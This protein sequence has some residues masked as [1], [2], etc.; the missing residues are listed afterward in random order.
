MTKGTQRHNIFT[1]TDFVWDEDKNSKLIHERG[2]SFE[3]AMECL[4][5]GK[6]IHLYKHPN[7]W[8]YP[9]QQIAVVEINQYAYLV[10]FLKT[11]NEI[12]LKSM[13]PSRKASKK[14]L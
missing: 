1:Q 11:G 8:K 13:F 12:C 9:G 5:E 10:P 14:Y 4:R 6:V 7:Q 3:Q 2:I